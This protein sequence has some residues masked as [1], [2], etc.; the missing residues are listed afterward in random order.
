MT[1]LRAPPG[2]RYGLYVLAIIFLLAGVAA[3]ILEWNSLAQGGSAFLIWS[4]GLLMIVASTKL[5]KA[6]NVRAKSSS[7]TEGDQSPIAPGRKRATWRLW[8][9]G[10]ASLTVFGIS[11]HYLFEDALRG[12]HQ[13]WPV[14]TFAGAAVICALVL[15]YLFA[16]LI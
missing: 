16:R 9:A 7:V 14:Y 5:V 15:G 3:L 11:Y 1:S 13:V 10:A 6:S 8:L 4:L 2:R 12:H